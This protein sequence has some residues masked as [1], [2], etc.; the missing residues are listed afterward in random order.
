MLMGWQN[1]F[2]LY[3]HLYYLTN[4]KKNCVFL[5]AQ[6][7]EFPDASLTWSKASAALPASFPLYLKIS[8]LGPVGSSS[9]AIQFS[10]F[11]LSLRCLLFI[12]SFALPIENCNYWMLHL[13]TDGIF[14]HF[15]LASIILLVTAAITWAVT[16]PHVTCSFPWLFP[17]DF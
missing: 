9:A 7:L 5:S 11:L 13:P 12:Y 3:Y 2:F 1:C 6:I 14:F 8:Q 16:P 15:I 17:T 10:G 4:E